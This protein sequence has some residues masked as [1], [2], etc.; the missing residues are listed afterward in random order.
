MPPGMTPPNVILGDITFSGATLAAVVCNAVLPNGNI[1]VLKSRASH[2]V[3][4]GEPTS[5]GGNIVE[6]GNIT[7]ED[8]VAT[9][10]IIITKNEVA[11]NLQVIKNRSTGDMS[12]TRNVVGANLQ[13]FENTGVFVGGPNSAQKAEGQ[14]F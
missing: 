11:Q 4:V 7:V 5:C 9:D 1:A 12:V 6:K 3:V 8:N 13:C 10:G 14:C 2:L